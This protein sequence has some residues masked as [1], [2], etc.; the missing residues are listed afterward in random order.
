MSLRASYLQF[1]F[2]ACAKGDGKLLV[3]HFDDCRTLIAFALLPQLSSP[4][5]V[6]MSPFMSSWPAR[7]AL[8]DESGTGPSMRADRLAVYLKIRYMVATAFAS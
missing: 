3:A 5:M 2:V 8:V 1:S 4:P 6:L 7:A